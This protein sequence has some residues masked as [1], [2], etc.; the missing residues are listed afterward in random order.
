MAKSLTD[1]L[2]DGRFVVVSADPD[3]RTLR[4]RAESDMCREMSCHEETLVTTD[5]GPG[6]L[7]TLNA[8]DIVKVSM[9]EGRAREIVV[10]RRVWEELSSP[11]F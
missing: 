11:E 4:V 9:A 7:G 8:G 1:E 2:Q 10:V 6:H 3:R 5:D